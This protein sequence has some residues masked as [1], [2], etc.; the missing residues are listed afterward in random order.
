MKKNFLIIVITLFVLF[1]HS[2]VYAAEDY[3]QERS[4]VKFT[5]ASNECFSCTNW[6]TYGSINIYGRIA[7]G[8]WYKSSFGEY[9][10]FT[11]MKVSDTAYTAQDFASPNFY[12]DVVY[13]NYDNNQS[14]TN[15]S[16]GVNLTLTGGFAISDGYVQLNYVA[17]NNS[18]TN[19][20]IS[21]G[22]HNDIQIS[23]ND[24]AA[25]TVLPNNIGFQMIDDEADNIQLNVLLKS[26]VGVTDVST[27]WIGSYF[28]N[29]ELNV[30]NNQQE[31]IQDIDSAMAYSW[32][33]Q[34][35]TPG[36]S[37]IY[38][39]LLTV[40]EALTNPIV[41]LSNDNKTKVYEEGTN[42]DGTVYPALESYILKGNIYD[43]LLTD[44][45][46]VYYKLNGGAATL[47]GNYEPNNSEFSITIPAN[48]LHGINTIEIYG[49]GSGNRTSIT[50]TFTFKVYQYKE[51]TNTDLG[52]IVKGYFI[53]GSSLDISKVT[54]ANINKAIG[55]KD[56]VNYLFEIKYD[57]NSLQNE[58]DL[59]YIIKVP[60]K[61]DKN[62]SNLKIFNF[63]K[64]YTKTLVNHEIT[65]DNITFLNTNINYFSISYGEELPVQN[66]DTGISI[67]TYITLTGVLGIIGTSLYINKR[68]YN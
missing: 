55:F 46:A 35:L 13:L 9:G 48:L 61:I 3:S 62:N 21:F 38:T 45:V 11:I 42:N 15:T 43:A 19:K 8:E 25:V 64:D 20:Y 29:E 23:D 63:T 32:Q 47:L 68:K 2:N 22:T 5:I 40:G 56:A 65:E 10:Y 1:F 33:N 27:F 39:V 12:D 58:E 59:L 67:Y 14:L 49:I 28:D 53:K 57:N 30:F 26:F 51:V 36:Q 6:P 41:T 17:T 37:K 31:G 50:K 18:S 44:N 24:E 54:E 4:T 16:N 60:E 34:L 66:P 7:G 52:I